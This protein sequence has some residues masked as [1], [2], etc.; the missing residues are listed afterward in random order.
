MMT[1]MPII[2]LALVLF[3]LHLIVLSAQPDFGYYKCFIGRGTYPNGSPYQTNLNTLLSNFS[4]DTK[5]DYGFYSS[6]FGERPNI[7]HA[8]GLCRGDLSP[9]SC[10]NCLTVAKILLPRLCPNQKDAFGY[11]DLCTF[12]Y[13]SRP[14]LGYLDPEFSYSFNNPQDAIDVEEYTSAL[15]DLLQRL[16]SEAA[17]GDSRRKVAV[18]SKPAG[19]FETVYG[20]VQC[21][22]DMSRQNCDAC[23][24]KAI[25]DIPLCCKNKI[26]GR[27]IK[28]SCNL[29]FEK[30]QFYS[31]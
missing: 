16:K 31:D 10:R 17:S 18:G 3:L 26:G 11:F 28:L 4:S 15:H 13:S 24:E 5:I 27:V 7:V 29:R 30:G 21:K 9:S 25:S 14:L 23:L 1:I 6:T 12:Q 19:Q 22:P 8:Q 2:S 20:L